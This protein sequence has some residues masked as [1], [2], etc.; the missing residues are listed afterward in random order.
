MKLFFD[1]FPIVL[2]F[3]AY[4]VFDI[5]VATG[6]A[7]A[8]TVVQ[9]GYLKWAG[10]K[11]QTMMWISLGTILIA[12]GA[13][14]I[15]KNEMFIK[16]KPTILFSIGAIAIAVTQFVFKKNPVAV[17]FNDQIQA[18][19]AV[20][21]KLSLAWISFLSFI[22][23]LNLYFAYYQSTDNWAYFHTFGTLVLLMIFIV[24]QMFWLLPYMPTDEDDN[25]TLAT[26]ANS[27]APAAPDK[28]THDTVGNH[29][30][31]ET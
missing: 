27:P 28:A 13:A 10:K 4:K 11:V 16:I 5:Y 24:A 22:S 14:I 21:K 15:F 2:F 26:A 20:W 19:D 18:P 6:V 8:A 1:I 7:I 3:V 30:A 25:P 17:M 31:K 29:N 9:V 23:A 12:G